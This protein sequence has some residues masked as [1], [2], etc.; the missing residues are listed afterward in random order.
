MGDATLDPQWW[1][2]IAENLARGATPRDL[3][4]A[5]LEEGVPVALSRA[6]IA[7]LRDSPVAEIAAGLRRRIAAL[8]QIVA[9][10]ARHRDLS[11]PRPEPL[12]EVESF[13]QRHWRPGT[14]GIFTDIVRQWPAFRRWSLADFRCRFG[15][16][17]VEACVGRERLADADPLWD[18]CAAT[19]TLATFIDRLEAGSAN[20]AYI[21]A[22]N[23]LLQRPGLAPLLEDIALRPEVFG[24]S[25]DLGRIALWLGGAGTH[26]PL[27]HDGDNTM[28]CQVVGRKRFRMAPPEQLALLD[29]ARGV[30]NLWDP[31]EPEV[32]AESPGPLV[33]LVLEPGDALFIPAGWWHQV[34]AL[35]PSISVSI[36]QFAWPNDYNWYRPGSVLRGT[37]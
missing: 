22:K 14:P 23:A 24:E 27:H 33:E 18:R 2:W 17:T 19:M 28:F 10:R 36:Q 31:C 29:H 8:E 7:H 12:P 11:P 25:V 9:L 6:A 35:D 26:T 30:F 21:I 1:A 15:D 32:A 16:E 20:D 13:V 34:D 3:E 5:L 4:D 37:A